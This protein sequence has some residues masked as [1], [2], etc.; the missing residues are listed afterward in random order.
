MVKLEPCGHRR[1]D[2]GSSYLHPWPDKALVLIPVVNS[3]VAFS[4]LG[5]PCAHS[6]KQTLQRLFLSWELM[7]KSK[8]IPGKVGAPEAKPGELG[9]V[10]QLSWLDFLLR[11]L[12]MP[13]GE[14]AVRGQRFSALVLGRK[15]TLG[16]GE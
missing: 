11:S 16:A 8:C 13:A 6:P 7:S 4:K 14:R 9:F 12:L 3:P 2:T 10:Q 15:Q 1:L 5:F